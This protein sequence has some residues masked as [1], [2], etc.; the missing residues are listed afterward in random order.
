MVVGEAG[1][2]ILELLPRGAGGTSRGTTPTR[3]TPAIGSSSSATPRTAATR[4]R[5]FVVAEPGGRLRDVGVAP[6]AIAD[7]QADGLRIL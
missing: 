2:G 3:G 5:R 6:T 4:C 1:G 7:Y